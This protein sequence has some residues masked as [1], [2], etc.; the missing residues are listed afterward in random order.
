MRSAQRYLFDRSF[1]AE[2]PGRQFAIVSAEATAVPLIYTSEDLDRARAEGVALGRAEALAEFDMERE[3]GRLRQATLDAIAGRLGELLAGSAKASEQAARDAVAI[4]AA[5]ARK[6]LPRLYRERASS[7][8]E[9]LVAGV[10]AAIGDEPKVIVR[11]SPDLV[12]ELAPAIG[13]SIAASR[14][15]KRLTVIGDP[16]VGEGDCRIDLTGGGVIR[17]QALLWREIDALLTEY[18]AQG[19]ARPLSLPPPAAASGERHV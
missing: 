13:A 12:G 1:E 14:H 19:A 3:I 2:L 6:L 4:A 9:E 18:A 15:E 10:L 16:A 8:I 11:I 17:D 5:I 7:E